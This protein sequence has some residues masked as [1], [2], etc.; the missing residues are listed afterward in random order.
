MR[1]SRR[2]RAW[3]RPR[4]RSSA[5][6]GSPRV[7]HR[8]RGNLFG[9]R[10]VRNARP[11]ASRPRRR[12]RVGANER[13]APTT[14]SRSARRRR[15]RRHHRV[16]PRAP[17]TPRSA[18]RRLGG[19]V[20]EGRHIASDPTGFRD[21]FRRRYDDFG[22]RKRS[23]QAARRG[24]EP[25][26]TSFVVPSRARPSSRSTVTPI[27]GWSVAHV[28]N[29]A[30]ALRMASCTTTTTASRWTSS[31]RSTASR[32]EGGA[33]ASFAG[34]ARERRGRVVVTAPEEVSAE[35]FVEEEDRA[36]FVGEGVVSGRLVRLVAR[37]VGLGGGPNPP[38]MAAP[39]P[40]K[41]SFVDRVRPAG[42]DESEKPCA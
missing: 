32:V 17:S 36:P 25:R 28:G 23:G 21:G 33:F 37:R 11:S 13:P 29:F 2:R 4:D 41:V 15:V 27:V 42:G 14:P 24:G 9:R 26:G 40:F 7:P 31:S 18:R 12:R 30:T 20:G 1:R 35:E 39:E 16:P 34:D 22:S 3:N 38:R 19:G 6:R 5:S 8:P 10:R